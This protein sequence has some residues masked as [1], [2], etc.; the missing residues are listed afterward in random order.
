[1]ASPV[2]DFERLRM[3]ERPASLPLMRQRWQRLAFLHWSVDP[4]ALSALLPPNIELDTWEGKAYVGIVPFGVRGSR[5][6]FLPPIPG[7]SNFNELNVRTYVHRRGRDPGVWFFS[8][9]AA[10]LLAVWGARA[11]YKL[12]YFHASIALQHS[13]DSTSFSSVR[14][15]SEQQPQFACSYQP[16]SAPAP[17]AAGTL[18]FFLIERYLLYSWDDRRL[19]T[20]RVWHQPYPVSEARIHRLSQN[21]AAAVRIELD[22]ECAPIA[23]Y[24]EGVDVRIYP[25]SLVR[26][27]GDQR[28]AS[29]S[30]VPELSPAEGE[31]SV[32]VP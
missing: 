7:L 17:V 27:H 26:V 9:D 31:L 10:S 3:R 18:E 29:F 28:D 1:M 14:A 5:A 23:H 12:P 25:P 2:P 20:A 24:S 19:R 30:V 16:A 13:Q 15:A 32:A 4:I 21:V 22:P 8:L 11:V 6:A